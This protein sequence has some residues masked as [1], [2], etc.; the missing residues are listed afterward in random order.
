MDLVE[1]LPTFVGKL[2][3]GDPLILLPRLPTN[4]T[5][6]WPSF[7]RGAAQDA[8]VSTN[9]ALRN[10]QLAGDICLQKSFERFSDSQEDLKCCAGNF[11]RIVSSKWRYGTRE[12]HAGFSCK[13][14]MSKLCRSLRVDSIS[15]FIGSEAASELSSCRTTRALSARRSVKISCLVKLSSDIG[16]DEFPGHRG[17]DDCEPQG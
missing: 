3:E 9:G 6:T 13:S 8:T 4:K 12:E 5:H 16:L 17:S 2:H 11:A 15:R 10:A 1:Q 14:L 7:L